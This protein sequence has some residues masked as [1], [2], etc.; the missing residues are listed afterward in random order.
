MTPEYSLL[1][2]NPSAPFPTLQRQPAYDFRAQF[3]REIIAPGVPRCRY[4]KK[5]EVL[6]VLPG[7]AWV[8]P[9]LRF[10]SSR[11]QFVLLPSTSNVRGQIRVLRV[12]VTA[13]GSIILWPTLT[14]R[15]ASYQSQQAAIHAAQL[16]WVRIWKE[17]DG[18]RHATVALDQSPSYPTES[19]AVLAEKA[20][21]R[22]R[23][24]EGA[25]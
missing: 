8:S 7:E 21:L 25:A 18:Y 13:L 20:G 14:E 12:A 22:P 10:S 11:Q 5:D 6:Q 1:P 4:P 2:F 19:L 3:A 9:P 16:G 24:T 17:R 15:K 23:G